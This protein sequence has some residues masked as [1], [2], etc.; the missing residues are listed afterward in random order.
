LKHL[1]REYDKAVEDMNAAEKAMQTQ[2][3]SADRLRVVREFK[4]KL[5]TKMATLMAELRTRCGLD[6][7]WP[8]QE[9]LKSVE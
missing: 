3:Y 9:V 6:E 1:K 8:A 5:E 4:E 2:N 7:Q